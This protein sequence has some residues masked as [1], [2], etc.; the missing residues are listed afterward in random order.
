LFLD[1][2]QEKEGRTRTTA[3]EEEEEALALAGS[4]F[5]SQH[6]VVFLQAPAK[7]QQTEQPSVS[8]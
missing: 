3:K 4:I 2:R 1:H 7:P 5:C 6:I 8:S